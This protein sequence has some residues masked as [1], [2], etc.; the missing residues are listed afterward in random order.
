MLQDALEL[1]RPLTMVTPID[2]SILSETSTIQLHLGHALLANHDE[3]GAEDGYRQALAVAEE[4]LRRAPTSL[5]FQRDRSNVLEALG[6]FHA[7]RRESRAE[8]R[9][10]IEKSLA[11]WRD[12]ASRKIGAPY[13]GVRE[14][15]AA[16][17]LAEID[18][19]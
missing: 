9:K 18:R 13:A 2:L 16:A 7:R 19:N 11:I 14:R 15:Q 17:L 4:S 8:A 10:Y 6:R 12:W 5:Y 3:R 1:L